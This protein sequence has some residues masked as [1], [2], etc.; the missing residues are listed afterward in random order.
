M[1][2]YKSHRKG[3]ETYNELREITNFQQMSYTK[4]E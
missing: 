1:I 3:K 4:V 2:T